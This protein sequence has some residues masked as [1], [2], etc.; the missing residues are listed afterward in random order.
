MSSIELTEY[1]RGGAKTEK[2]AVSRCRFTAPGTKGSEYNNLTDD[3]LSDARVT[4]RL[5]ART[6][7]LEF[8]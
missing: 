6:T 5:K 2:D 4:I 1:A 8:S 7:R 3:R